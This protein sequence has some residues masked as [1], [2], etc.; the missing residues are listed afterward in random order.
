MPTI[1]FAGVCDSLLHRVQVW[2]EKYELG[3]VYATRKFLTKSFEHHDVPVQYVHNVP[4]SLA[5]MTHLVRI[6]TA[7]RPKWNLTLDFTR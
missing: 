2:G 7:E 1:W 4:F 3:T 6:L 5:E